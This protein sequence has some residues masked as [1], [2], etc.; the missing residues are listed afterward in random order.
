M[1]SSGAADHFDFV[2]VG[3]GVVGL[4]I[5]RDLATHYTS[6]S[7]LVI[8]RHEGFGREISSHNSEVVHAGIYYPRNSLKATT[9]VEGRDL[10]YKYC[11][12]K[13]VRFL[14]CG[15]YVVASSDTE[16]N[17]LEQI[18]EKAAANGVQLEQVSGRSLHTKL[19]NEKIISALWSKTSG[20]VDSHSLMRALEIEIL[21]AG[22]N[23]IYDHELIEAHDNGSSLKLMLRH[24]SGEVYAVNASTVINSAGLGARAVANLFGKGSHFNIKACRGRYFNLSARFGGRYKNLIYPVPDPRGGLGIHL[25]IDADL[26]CRLGPDVDWSLADQKPDE[27]SLYNFN[28]DDLNMQPN[29]FESGRKLIPELQIE[30][31]SPGYIGVRPKLFIDDKPFTDFKIENFELKGGRYVH[32]LGIESPGLTSALSLSS[33]LLRSFA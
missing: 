26:N 14:N 23:V 16:V 15:K 17:I 13:N 8:D 4:A 11:A 19:N 29:F 6:K 5:G 24:R 28:Q 18:K 10:L 22:Q 25:T 32:L 2:V 1:S 33:V 7:V 30:D 27:W 20:I 31:L 21:D 12:K 9:C 3:A